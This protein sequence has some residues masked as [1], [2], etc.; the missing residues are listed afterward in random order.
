METTPSTPSNHLLHLSKVKCCRH[1]CPLPSLSILICKAKIP[2]KGGGWASE[3]ATQNFSAT[4]FQKMWNWIFI[5]GNL[6]SSLG[7]RK[8]TDI[9]SVREHREHMNHKLLP[10]T[11]H[12]GLSLDRLH[13]RSGRGWPGCSHPRSNAV[14]HQSVQWLKVLPLFGKWTN[15]VQPLLHHCLILL[16][17]TLNSRNNSQN[18]ACK[19]NHGLFIP[20]DCHNTLFSPPFIQILST[21]Q[22]SSSDPHRSFTS[23]FTY[24]K[25]ILNLYKV[26]Y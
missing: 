14:H 22:G 18:W 20:Q 9:C 5:I 21:C 4:V 12:C 19:L 17:Q 15:Y 11:E 6:P 8:Q 13:S 2:C 16:L 23:L 26:M 10:G 7:R 25:W 1:S 24:Q 3:L